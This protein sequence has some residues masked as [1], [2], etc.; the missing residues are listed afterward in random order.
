[1]RRSAALLILA[2]LAHSLPA[3]EPDARK[4]IQGGLKFL[5]EEAVAR[6]R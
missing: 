6:E 4:A 5:A 3:A 2:G 1:M